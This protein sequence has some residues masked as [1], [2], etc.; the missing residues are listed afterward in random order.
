MCKG[1]IS[2]KG[3]L[4]KQSIKIKTVK[5]HL[6]LVMPFLKIHITRKHICTCTQRHTYKDIH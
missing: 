2:F 1:K 5:R 3:N 6:N 4:T